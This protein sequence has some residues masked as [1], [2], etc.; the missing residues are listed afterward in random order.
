[1]MK[2]LFFIL[3]FV[4]VLVSCSKDIINTNGTRLV[5]I[6]YQQSNSIISTWKELFE[7]ENGRITKIEDLYSLR[8]RYEIIYTN[9]QLQEYSTYIIS[10]N[11]L[12]FRDSVAY[13]QNG[14]IRAVYNFITNPSSDTPLLF[15]DE[16]EYS[17]DG[18]II[19]KK[20]FSVAR[21]M[22]RSTERYYWNENNIEKTE[23]YNEEGILIYETSTTYDSKI[24]YKKDIPI[25]VLSPPGWNANNIIKSSLRDY[26][27]AIDVACNPCETEYKYNLDDYPVFIEHHEGRQLNLSYE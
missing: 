2:K 9:N 4:I 8:K 23:Y 24:N 19:T 22:Y 18:K 7:Y 10:D 17:D 5:A 11:T 3:W 16:F 25:Y 12:A 21:E 26:T 14:T 6:D 20:N 13:N 15:I 1:M 27:G